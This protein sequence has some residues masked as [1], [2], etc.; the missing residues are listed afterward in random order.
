[1][2]DSPKKRFLRTPHVQRLLDLS[3]DASVLAAFDAAILQ[4]QW[5]H[6]AGKTPDTAAA[7]HWQMTGAERLREL[8]L[9]IA[10]VSKPP[11]KPP[12]DNLP[13]EV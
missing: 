3:N 2:I 5:E 4:M 8:F 11:A 12:S 13:H 1:M 10:V 6:G 9:T 7:L